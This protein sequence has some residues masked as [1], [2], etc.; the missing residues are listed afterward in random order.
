LTIVLR[1]DL[2]GVEFFAMVLILPKFLRFLLVGGLNTIVGFI[3]FSLAI[4]VTNENV[5][6]SLAVN[7]G[8][9]VFFNFL[10]YGYGVFRNLGV[11]RFIKFVCSYVIIY[12]INYFVL[13]AMMANG[14]NVYLAQFIN[15]FY[16]APISY[17]VFNRWVFN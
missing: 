6:L 8:V 9:G 13:A 12:A 16:L 1:A 7:I 15:L 10:S 5:S 3:V 4:Y 2:I 11:R 14:L 17:L